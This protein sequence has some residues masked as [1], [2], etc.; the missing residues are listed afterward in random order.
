M[1]CI[2]LKLYFTREE[3][4]ND[5]FQGMEYVYTVYKEKS[6]SKAAKSL[7]ISQ[8]S[9][10]ATIKRVENRIGY[11][12]FDRSTKPLTLTECGQ[13]YIQAIEHILAIEGSFH[14]Y[15]NDWG[16]LK[17][18]NLV[19]G[20]SSLYSS[21][22]LPSMMRKFSKKYPAVKVVLVEES[23]SKL[24]EML[25]EGLIDMFI[26]NCSLDEEIYAHSVYQKEHLFLAVP[27]RM[28]INQTVQEYQIPAEK[29]KDGSYLLEN[30]ISVPLKLFADEPFVVLKQE[31]DTR[32]RAMSICQDAGFTPQI[33]FELDQQMT[34]YHITSSGMGISFVSDTLISQ[35]PENSRVVYYK[36]DGKDSERNLSFYWKRG[37]YVSR[38]MEEFLK[39]AGA[40]R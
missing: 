27:R 2:T 9:L 17:T 26:D 3:I 29:I 4:M 16:E 10:S 15:V 34:S 32:K 40:G 22:V 24:E 5:L 23:T 25:L 39:I 36:L 30:P 14:D 31:N 20:G 35:M 1:V 8:P 13:K 12:I 21:L 7:F 28:P 6:F 18:G 38:A 33:L 37:R 19:L 11:P